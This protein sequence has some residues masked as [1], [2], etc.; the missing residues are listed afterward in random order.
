MSLDALLFAPS[1]APAWVLAVALFGLVVGSFANVCIH[2]IPRRES[3]VHPRSR[4]PRCGASIRARHNLPVLSWLWLRGRCAS[5]RAPISWRYPAVEAANGILWTGLALAQ[6]PRL[7]TFLAMLLGTAL[8]VLALIDYDHKLLP[9]RITLPGIA[10]GVLASAIPGA[11]TLRGSVAAAAGG[12]L[13]LALVAKAYLTARGVEGLGRGDWKMAAM[14][15]AFFG[16]QKLLL[17]VFLATLAGTLV[18]GAL[19]L[20][21]VGS[22]RSELPLGTFLGL[23][24]IVVLFVGD[25]LLEWYAGFF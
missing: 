17:T 18:G 14:L 7:G 4:C 2:R 13:G 23:A 22:R 1:D 24:G 11:P 5:C 10:V 8:L 12:Y 6:G 19:I 25:P 20:A 16:W 9:D 3:V 21:G 15:G